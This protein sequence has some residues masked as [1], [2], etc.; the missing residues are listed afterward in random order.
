MHAYVGF[1]IVLLVV[2][3]ATPILVTCLG[4]L[5]Y[6]TSFLAKVKP[7]LVWPS[8]VGSYHVRSLPFSLGNAPTIGQIWYIALFVIL[9]LALTAGGYK[10][11][12]YPSNAWFPDAWQEIMAYVS[13][14]TGVLAFALAPLVILF[15]GRNNVLLWLTNWSH[16]T[17][18]RVPKVCSRG[19]TSHNTNIASSTLK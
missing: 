14:R 1:R 3:F 10:S 13:A 2:S 17:Y 5:P 11:F 8:L 4:R 7:R 15:S 16:S 6:M 12:Q 18:S 19:R 9:N